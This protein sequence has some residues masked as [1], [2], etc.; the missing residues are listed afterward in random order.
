MRYDLSVAPPFGNF[1]Y[2]L[3]RKTGLFLGKRLTKNIANNRSMKN[4]QLNI[5]NIDPDYRVSFFFQRLLNTG[6]LNPKETARF[7]VEWKYLNKIFSSIPLE[8]MIWHYNA[9]EA[10]D[11]EVIEKTGSIV[12]FK[13]SDSFL[14]EFKQSNDDRARIGGKQNFNTRTLRDAF[15][16]QLKM[17]SS[18]TE[19]AA[20]IGRG[21]FLE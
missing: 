9:D 11:G 20:K 19:S 17:I 14:K 4:L 15:W 6:S 1:G 2:L 8:R 21:I 7:D 5:R 10:P 3:Y 16:Y 12:V 18:I 13:P